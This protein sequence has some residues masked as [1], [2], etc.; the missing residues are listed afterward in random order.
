MSLVTGNMLLKK[1]GEATLVAGTVTVSETE[2]T[3]DSV[4]FITPQPTGDLDGI[5]RVSTI[6]A[7]TSFVIT[8]TDNT[9]T[10]VI[11]YLI[12]N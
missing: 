7:D 3:E 8:S 9:D 10:A 4:I 12:F 1:C 2:V 5:V 11:A 6:T